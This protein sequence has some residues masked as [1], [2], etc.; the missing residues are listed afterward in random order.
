MYFC[1]SCLSVHRR[2]VINR[3][4][5]RCSALQDQGSQLPHVNEP[6]TKTLFLTKLRHFPLATTSA[7]K[8]VSSDH[9]PIKFHRILRKEIGCRTLDRRISRNPCCETHPNHSHRPS[10]VIFH[11]YRSHETVRATS[12][13]VSTRIGIELITRCETK[14]KQT[15]SLSFLFHVRNNEQFLEGIDY[16]LHVTP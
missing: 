2:E 14:C 12:P 10:C 8:E 15:K 16:V 4:K 5:S 1:L 6:R 11:Q 13:M 3:R 7:R 9:V